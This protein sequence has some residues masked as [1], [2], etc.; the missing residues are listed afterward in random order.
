[1]VFED[2]A[3]LMLGYAMLASPYCVMA[4]GSLKEG[5]V[6]LRCPEVS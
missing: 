3:E 4:G 2:L 1:M 5:F 6:A